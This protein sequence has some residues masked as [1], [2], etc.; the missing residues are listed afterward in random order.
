MPDTPPTP[1]G[2]GDERL[3]DKW[4]EGTKNYQC[5]WYAPQF[6]IGLGPAI[7]IR[8]LLAPDMRPEHLL[9]QL[10]RMVHELTHTLSK[11]HANGEEEDRRRGERPGG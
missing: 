10:Q 5:A 11:E 6:D 3:R 1:A 4:P 7:R 9:W 2:A 8:L